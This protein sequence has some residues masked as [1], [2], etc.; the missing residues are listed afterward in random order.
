VFLGINISLDKSAVCNF[1]S[2]ATTSRVGSGIGL[3]TTIT[4]G[5]SSE[6]A[7]NANCRIRQC[8]VTEDLIPAT[9]IITGKCGKCWLIFFMDPFWLKV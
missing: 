4:I 8:S 2:A 9:H 5:A 1:K 3:P 6:A 7:A